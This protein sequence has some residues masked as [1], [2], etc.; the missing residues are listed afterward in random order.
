MVEG[1]V[2][3]RLFDSEEKQCRELPKVKHKN[4]HRVDSISRLDET[5]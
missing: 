5:E 1:G 4:K 3:Y 2:Q